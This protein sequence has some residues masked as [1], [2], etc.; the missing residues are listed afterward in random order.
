MSGAGITPDRVVAG[1]ALPYGLEVFLLGRRL[2]FEPLSLFWPDGAPIRMLRDH[3]H[4]QR[5]GRAVDLAH[6]PDGLDPTLVVDHGPAGDRALAR[7]A[8]GTE[9]GLSVGV[10]FVDVVR[11]RGTYVVRSALLREISL[12]TRPVVATARVTLWPGNTVR[13]SK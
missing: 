9:R 1:L 8:D 3:D 4:S 7:I 6:T 5:L 2:V 13:S 12:T 10:T 11:L